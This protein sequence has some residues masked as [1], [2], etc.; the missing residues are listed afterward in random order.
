MEKVKRGGLW[1][2]CVLYAAAVLMLTFLGK[3]V[4]TDTIADSLVYHTNV[5]PFATVWDWISRL[6]SDQIN[7]GI[8]IS[9]VFGNLLLLMPLGFLLPCTFPKMRSLI[10]CLIMSFG[11]TLFLECAQ[12]ML[13]IGCFDIDVFL[14]R[15][16]GTA[17]GYWVYKLAR[18][19]Y[20]SNH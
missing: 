1:A 15:I 17:I 6:A 8:V 3:H 10:A 16:V 14:L 20:E 19:I 18:G 12:I 9:N 4:L 7:L 2:A 5:I 11:V 13:R